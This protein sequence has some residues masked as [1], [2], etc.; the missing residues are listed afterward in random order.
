MGLLDIFRRREPSTLERTATSDFN[1][2][3]FEAQVGAFWE[4]LSWTAGASAPALLE[5]VWVANRCLHMNA[6]AISTMPLRHYGTREPTWVSNPDPVWYPNGISDAVYAIVA[7]LY[8]YGD[9]FVYVTNRYADGYPSAWTVLDPA[10]M[11]VDVRNGRRVY[12]SGQER[13]NASDM[14][15]I[16]RDPRGGVRGTS[17]IKSYAAYTNG[18]LASADLGRV[19]MATGTPT[20]VLKAQKKI[21]A[22]QALAVQTAWMS[23]TSS[24]R[25][26]PAVIGPDLQFERLG[27]SA[28]DLQLLS[29]QQ[30]TAQVVATAFGVPASLVNMPLEGG[31]TYDTPILALEQWWR[32]ELRT[33]ATRISGALSSV[34]LPA[35]QYVEFDP[36]KFVAPAWKELVDGWA[37][38]VEKGLATVEQFQTA[39]LGVPPGQQPDLADMAT[40]PSAGAS[41]A[42]GNGRLVPLRPTTSNSSVF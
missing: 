7:S 15:Q 5:R 36:Y 37:T 17:A 12:R 18:L 9:A 35:G 41:P 29:M 1:S 8:G 10:P 4:S 31:L 33:T 42:Q 19:M 39:V 13:L 16:T 32:T 2:P 20:S 27:F 28:E 6:N 23:A 25:G 30:F 21:T 14:V 34:M 22:E 11:Q 40:P 24:R 38:L 26:A 3:A